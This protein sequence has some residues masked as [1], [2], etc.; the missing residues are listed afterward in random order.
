MLSSVGL[1]FRKCVRTAEPEL[2]AEG[3]VG[4][5]GDTVVVAFF[6][7]YTNKYIQIQM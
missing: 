2:E 3:Q 7:K 6:H 4:K 5:R 1:T